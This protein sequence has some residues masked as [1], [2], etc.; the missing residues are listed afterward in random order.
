MVFGR[1]R[2]VE[3]P[4]GVALGPGERVL[5]RAGLVGG[6][7]AIA[8]TERLLVDRPAGG[9]A[10]A[11]TDVV[12]A[13]LEAE[14]GALEVLLVD[15]SRRA[16]LLGRGEGRAFVTTARE[17]VQHSV[18]LARTVEFGRRS[19]RVVA[20]RGPRGSFVQVV[21][22]PGVDLQRP[23]VAAAVAEAE[24]AVRE[25]VGLPP[26]GSQPPSTK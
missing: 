15:G 5:A 14:E 17:R 10:D 4:G 21:P 13:V 22:S 20:R 12:S 1:R 11:W 26:G 9:S 3:L 18:L 24:R 23:D 25:Q 16:L 6:G 19:V 7:T 2:R 8:T